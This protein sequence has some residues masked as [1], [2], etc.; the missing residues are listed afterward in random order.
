MWKIKIW[1]FF[2]Q[3]QGSIMYLATWKLQTLPKLL[4]KIVSYWGKKVLRACSII[5]FIDRLIKV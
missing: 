5:T 2:P 4:I 3:P 1:S